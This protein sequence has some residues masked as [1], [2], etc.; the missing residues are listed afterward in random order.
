[1]IEEQADNVICS[2]CLSNEGG[3]RLFQT[4]G[5]NLPDLFRDALADGVPIAANAG[6]CGTAAFRRQPVVC[7]DIASDP[8][9][10]DYRNAALNSGLQACWST[11]IFSSSGAVLGAFAMYYQEPRRPAAHEHVLIAAATHVAGIAIER[12]RAENALRDSEQRLRTIVTNAPVVLFAVNNEGTITLSEG[13]GLDLLGRKPGETVGTSVFET[14]RDAPVVLS[15]MR[16]ALA[17]E[18]FSN[19]VELSGVAFETHHTP[20]RESTGEVSGLIGVAFDV[21]ERLRAE[22]AL[23]ESESKFRT[24]AET[25]AAAVFIF[26]GDKMRYVNPAAETITGLSKQQLLSMNFWDVVHPEFRELV[27]ERGLA[28]QQGDAAPNAYEV[29]LLTN[30]GQEKWVD[31]TA[32]IIDFEGAPAVLG[33]AFDI[34][35]RKRAEMLLQLA[36]NRDPL[37]GLFNRRAGLAAVEERLQLAKNAGHRFSTMILDLDKFKSI[38]DTYSHETG[39]AALVRF[40]QVMSDL[41]ADRGVICRLGG[42]E[43]QIGI[44]GAGL[45][46]VVTIAEQL[47]AALRRS[48]QD[49]KLP[50]FRVSIGVACY[51]EDGATT[52]ELGRRADEAMYAAKAHGGDRCRAWRHLS[53]REAA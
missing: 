41:V 46:D 1:M 32:G 7:D 39:D 52:E 21:T 37:T 5:P 30:D 50:A 48:L 20:I 44:D 25:V 36:A 43:F 18:S 13:R 51:P 28:R 35:E 3:T 4:A 33:T 29:K 42:D 53:S 23:R 45:E 26:Q 17:G 6:C 22:Q 2:V 24:M 16:R 40:S 27:R 14:Y 31:F 34:T 49:G 9:W 8:L 12:K 10:D 47:R 19:I 15:N 11:P 38:N